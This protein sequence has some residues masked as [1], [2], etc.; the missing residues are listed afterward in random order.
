MELGY[1]ISSEEHA[2]LDLV[3]NAARAEEAGF[4]Y[5]LVS[6]HFHPWIDRQGSSPFVW[7]VLGGIAQ[8]TERLRVGTGVTCPTIRIHPAI[9]AQAAATA[10]AMLPGR[11][12]LGD[13]GFDH[14]Y[15]HRVGPDQDG[16][17]RFAERELLPR[18]AKAEAVA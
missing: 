7:G 16:F 8:R 12:F 6:D 2:P 10:A 4:G 5:A 3:A 11:F 15:V 14:V 13:A 17:L 9:V 18:Y 1:A